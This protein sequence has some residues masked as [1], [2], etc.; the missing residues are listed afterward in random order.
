MTALDHETTALDALDVEIPCDN[1]RC[2]DG[3]LWVVRWR[4]MPCCL[5][6][7]LT[8]DACLESTRQWLEKH[9]GDTGA[10]SEHGGV[11]PLALLRLDAEP[12]NPS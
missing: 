2:D 5:P 12:L 8:C 7:N 9:R 10:C 4:G 3:A 11:V 1:P 6:L